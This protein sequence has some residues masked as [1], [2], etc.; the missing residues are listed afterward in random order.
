M[1]LLSIRS[2]SGCRTGATRLAD[3]AEIT[4]PVSRAVNA[5]VK[6]IC[7]AGLRNF[8]VI[9]STGRP[10]SSAREHEQFADALRNID[11]AVARFQMA[12]AQSAYEYGAYEAHVATHPTHSLDLFDDIIHA[13]RER[14]QELREGE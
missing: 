4:G 7:E 12:V 13:C 9:D 2:E 11:A 6:E 10:E 3:R 5:L 1:S 14:A 8:D